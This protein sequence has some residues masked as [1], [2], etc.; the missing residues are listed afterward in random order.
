M[1]T[2][3]CPDNICILSWGAACP[4]TLITISRKKGGGRLKLDP[5]REKSTKK[6]N[7]SDVFHTQNC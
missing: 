2:I 7:L 5:T 3:V 6:I 1:Y 4:K